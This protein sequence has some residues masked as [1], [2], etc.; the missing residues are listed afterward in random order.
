MLLHVPPTPFGVAIIKPTGNAS[1]K[2]MLL[3][4]GLLMGLVMVNVSRAMPASLTL[5]MAVPLALVKALVSVGKL[6]AGVQTDA[7]GIPPPDAATGDKTTLLV[8]PVPVSPDCKVQSL[9][10]PVA[11]AP[12]VKGTLTR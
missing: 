7:A 3:T 12:M 8:S 11:V 5:V 2:L 9:L 10:P 4:A 6:Y 1:I